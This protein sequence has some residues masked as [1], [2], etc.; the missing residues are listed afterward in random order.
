MNLTLEQEIVFGPYKVSDLSPMMLQWHQIK[1]E[2]SQALLLFRLGDFYEAFFND[3]NDLALA[4]S[5]TLTK[6]Q[7]IPMAGVPQHMLETYLDR[8][9]QK[10]FLVA[11]AEQVEDPKSTKGIVKRALTRVESP[12]TYAG[13]LDQKVVRKQFFA[14]IFQFKNTYG[15]ALVDLSTQYATVYEPES[16]SQLVDL[17]I[18]KLPKEILIDQKFQEQQ[19]LFLLDLEKHFSFRLSVG[20]SHYFHHDTSVRFLLNHF[21][22]LQL[23]GL[24]LT[25]KT[26]AINAAGALLHYLKDHQQNI[27]AVQR[28]QIETVSDHL[29]I[30]HR[31]DRHLNISSSL[32]DFFDHTITA[33]GGR[34]FKEV[35]DKP[36]I[37]PVKIQDR[38]Q[39]TLSF[40]KRPDVLQEIRTIFNQVEDLERL[41]YRLLYAQ[42]STKEL[43]M[44]HKSLGPLLGLKEKMAPLKNS[45]AYKL[46]QEFPEIA[47][48]FE[49]LDTQ[50][51]LPGEGGSTSALFK[52]GVHPQIDA[53]RDF[54]EKGDR[55][56]IDYQEKLRNDLDIKTLKVSFTRAFGYYI[57]VSRAQSQKI[58]DTFV[59]RQTLVQQERYL[60]KELQEFEEKTLSAEETLKRLEEI[61][62]KKLIDQL[63]SQ[64]TLL[65]KAAHTVAQIDLFLSLACIAQK[66]GYVC[67]RIEV[68]ADL[69]IE[70][71]RHPLIETLLPYQGFIPN[72]LHL[73]DGKR[74]GLITG[75]NMGGKSTFI[76][77]TALII[78][79]AQIGAFVPAKS[80]T[81]S[82]F[83]R[84]FSRI[85]AN[86]DLYRGQST[87]MVEMSETAQ[88]LSNLT[89]SS[90][91]ILDEIGRGTGTYD[92]ISI[93]WSVLEYLAKSPKRPKTL[94]A[95][96]YSEL[97]E[98]M[99]LIEGVFNLKVLVKET[100]QGIH[101]TYK[102]VEGASDKSYGIHVA[103]LAG[104]PLQIVSRSQEILKNLEKQRSQRPLQKGLPS[105]DQIVIF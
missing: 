79:L 65:K 32:L 8:L 56:L 72:S 76:R 75:P 105:N 33:M 48:L 10:G 94:F 64:S 83:D 5:V 95:T 77:Q 50:L 2:C 63:L 46:L 85:G 23:D 13:L 102:M 26:A 29:L 37:D 73:S 98:C 47:P 28:I 82:P 90:F 19:G 104:M 20:K 6:R 74:L 4:C 58:P 86:D 103:K 34:L 60:S 71:E 68:G 16:K 40:L 18:K 3:A 99:E 92:G 9:I 41:L 22:T 91:I 88:I 78:L 62:L 1:S 53:L 21:G 93:A 11:I 31:T 15:L 100:P 80:V 45:E 14:S 42:N 38:Q 52:K 87:F 66:E 59:R 67:P 30:D 35:L 61:A 25:G 54:M 43:F 44:I 17:L 57:E 96:H 51:L 49:L 24:G 81:L 101:F 27:Q 69:M 89:E 70:E 36:L 12:A 7:E 55:W 97:T 39:I 84:I